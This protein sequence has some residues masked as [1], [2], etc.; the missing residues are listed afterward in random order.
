[1]RLFFRGIYFPQRGAWSW[2]KLVAANRRSAWKLTREGVTA[3]RR[4]GKPTPS[5]F[6]PPSSS[7][8]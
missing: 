4:R 8:G 7:N 1:V 6:R 3:W 5:S 2:T